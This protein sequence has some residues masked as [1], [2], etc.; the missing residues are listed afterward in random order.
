LL[1]CAARF[2]EAVEEG[3]ELP[4]P[5]VELPDGTV[6][7]AD[8]EA[9]PEQLSRLTGRDISIWPP[10]PADDVEHY[11]RG[12]PDNADMLQELR[13]IFARLP[14]EPLPDL[15]KLPPEAMLSATFPGTYFDCFPLMLVS[16]AAF[17]T[18]A[19]AQPGSSFDRRRFRPNFVVETEAALGFPENDWLGRRLRV[20]EVVL[21]MTVECPRCVMTT[22]PVQE[23]P[24]DPAIMRAL[25]KENGGNL[26]VYARI[27]TPGVVR[28]G[29]PIEVLD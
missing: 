25:V 19:K 22:H 8:A 13:S 21:E 7:R 5:E 4:V 20:G 28:E 15:A 23:L 2:P 11:R 1:H 24:K 10:V 26:G 16:T 9:L 12:A 27:A 29:D 14:D 17:G 6:L 3:A 18:L